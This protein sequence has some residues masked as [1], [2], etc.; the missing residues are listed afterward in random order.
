[1]TEHEDRLT[2]AMLEDSRVLFEDSVADLD[3]TTRARLGDARGRAL[4]ELASP[5][6]L[7]RTWAGLPAA[8]AALLIVLVALPV[9]KRVTSEP[10]TGFGTVAAVDLEILLAEEELEMLADLEFY[11]WLDLQGLDETVGENEDG[12]G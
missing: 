11:E 8:T 1:M 10:E 4:G 3:A 9:L 5:A 12:V 6:R 2:K 7:A